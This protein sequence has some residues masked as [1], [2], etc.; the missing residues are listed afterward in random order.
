MKPGHVKPAPTGQP[1]LAG[2]CRA[3]AAGALALLVAF[4]IATIADADDG[5][6]NLVFT[7]VVVGVMPVGVS[8][9]RRAPAELRGF[10][11]LGVGALFAQIIGTVLWY[12][13]YLG[14]NGHD[15]PTYGIWSP[16]LYGSLLVAAAAIWRGVRHHV[17]PRDA[18]LDF[19]VVLAAAASA[20]IVIAVPLRIGW[21]FAAVDGIVRP[22]FA[23]LVVTLAASGLVG[24]WRSLPLPVAL[25]SLSLAFDAGG[26]AW[27]S[28][29]TAGGA[30]TSDRG[31]DALWMTAA[32]IALLAGLAIVAGNERSLRLLTREALPGVSPLSLLTIS[33]T[34]WA[35]AAAVV[36]IGAVSHDRPALFAGIGA[37]AW[38]GFAGLLRTSAALSEARA[39]YRELE[40]AHFSLEQAR[41]RTAA[42][43]AERD[44]MIAQLAQR[45]VELTAIQTMFGPLLD[46][47]D[48]RSEGRLRSDLEDTGDGLAE[49]LL[50]QR[51]EDADA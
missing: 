4:W 45:N 15:L 2:H 21:S 10:V 28:Y 9:F 34:A 7:A 23:L 27:F 3:L 48:E 47:A 19:S 22:L 6:L 8:A 32:I 11:G 17:Q 12:A 18:A 13:A 39:A 33:A 46:L 35:V 36:V 16:F 40:D 50:R 14:H 49:W 5:V 43:V 44:E 29:L 31:P 26:Q 37:A 20:A 1:W 41:E 24:R 38:I 51:A 42:V 25:V 30:Y